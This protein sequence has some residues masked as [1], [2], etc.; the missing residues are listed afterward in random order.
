MNTFPVTLVPVFY[1]SNRNIS[2]YLLCRWKN[3]ER[4]I[5]SS[6]N[7]FSYLLQKYYRT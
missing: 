5:K 1:M 2:R 6:R 4:Y 3:Y 7:Y